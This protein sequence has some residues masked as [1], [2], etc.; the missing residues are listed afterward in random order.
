MDQVVLKKGRTKPALQKHPW[1]FSGAVARIVGD[2]ADGDLVELRD[3]G[4]NFLA[5]GLLNRRSQIVVRLVNWQRDQVPDTAFWRRRLERAL[6]GRSA[7]AAYPVTD[8]YRLVHAEADGLPGLIVDRYGDYLVVQFLILG[9]ERRKKDIADL[10]MEL[11]APRGIWER[12]DAPVRAKEGL[13]AVSGL[14]RGDSLPERL[15]VLENARHFLVDLTAGQ[16]TGFYLDQRVNRQRVSTYCAG[17]TVLDAFC[18]S[19]GFSVYAATAGAGLLTLV[20][21][22]AD[23]LALAAENLRLN[24]RDIA[25]DEFLTANVFEQLRRFRTEGRTFDVVVLDPPKFAHSQAEVSRAARGYKDINLLAMQLL[26][27]GGILATFSCSGLVSAD[28]FQKIV[29]G[30]A[31]DAGR[32]VQILERLAQGPDHPILLTFPQSEYLKGLICRAW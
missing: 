25:E 6:A 26:S 1:I 2:P 18:Y 10:L 31:V 17:K 7:L 12:S 8:A 11:A 20:D 23:A 19:G 32:D 27:P 28:L 22:S 21:S 9:M 3:A 30:A 4:N 13:P 14:L 29:F 24:K 16:K 15:E 5:H